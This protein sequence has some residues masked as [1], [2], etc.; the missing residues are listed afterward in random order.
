MT[1]EDVLR[2]DE[3]K[4][5]YNKNKLAQGDDKLGQA[6]IVLSDLKDNIGM[7]KDVLTGNN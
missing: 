3:I 5:L 2:Y 7:I 1:Q 6:V 4:T